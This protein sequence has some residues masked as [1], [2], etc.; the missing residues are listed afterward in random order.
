MGDDD[1]EALKALMPELLRARL[2]IEDLSRNFRCP[3]PGHDDSTP[4]ATYYDREHLVYCHGCQQCWDVFALVKMLDGIGSFP[5]QA[6]AVADAVGYRLEGGWSPVPN[7]R[8]PPRKRPPFDRPRPAGGRDVIDACRR[9][10][11]ALY[12]PEG[13]VGR[14]YLHWRGFDDGDIARYGLGFARRPS[15]VMPE[16]S[17]Y[18]PEALGFLVIPYYSEGCDSATY[19]VLRTLT[20]GEA[21]N[22]EWRPKG[23]ASPVWREWMLSS[24]APVVYVA[25]GPLDGMAL[26]KQLGRPA[27]ALGGTGKAKRLSEVLYATPAH[28]RPGKIVICMD[29]D[30]AGRSTAARIARDLDVLCVPHATLPPY[31]G[32]E[33][34]AND[35][36]VARRGTD[37]R[38]EERPLG[39]GITP[40]H[41]TVWEVRDE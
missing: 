20:R 13:D 30:E 22:K 6:R 14:R 10:Y 19:A 17:V 41:T 8:R 3:D 9:A 5:E 16:F 31:P 21:V 37:W 24:G 35:W 40:Y 7:R 12:T 26:Q 32:G 33:K 23:I 27:M 38:F 15:D 18:E 36:L 11:D 2:G 1:K 25:E 39:C 4:S 34:D 29:E 28:L